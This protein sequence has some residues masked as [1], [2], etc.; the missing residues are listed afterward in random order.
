MDWS[1]FGK[2]FSFYQR[3]TD[4]QDAGCDSILWNHNTKGRI[5]GFNTY[6]FWTGPVGRSHTQ[7]ISGLSRYTNVCVGAPTRR[8]WIYHWRSDDVRLQ[9]SERLLPGCCKDVW[10]HPSVKAVRRKTAETGR[11]ASSWKTMRLPSGSWSLP[12]YTFGLFACSGARPDTDAKATA[13]KHEATSIFLIVFLNYSFAS[14]Q[15]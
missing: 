15:T 9:R 11:S 12:L 2:D 1:I 10:G 14:R 4:T 6:G 13:C 8:W 5:L 3:I 7:C